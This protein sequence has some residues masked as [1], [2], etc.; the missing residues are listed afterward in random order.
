[1]ILLFLRAPVAF[2]HLR[3]DIIILFIPMFL[4]NRLRA[5][6]ILNLLQK[7]ADSVGRITSPQS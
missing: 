7:Y 5:K 1:M 4:L 6:T 3:K 2:L